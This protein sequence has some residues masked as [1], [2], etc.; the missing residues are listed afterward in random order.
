[1]NRLNIY[2]WFLVVFAT[3]NAASAQF[4]KNS[5]LPFVSDQ[6]D[7]FFSQFGAPVEIILAVSGIVLGF[8]LAFLGALER[9]RPLTAF[10]AGALIGFLLSAILLENIDA[11]IDNEIWVSTFFA[12]GVVFGLICA[13][14]GTFAKV[15][16][17][18]ALGISFT[19]LVLQSGIPISQ[20]VTIGILA[21]SIIIG[22]IISCKV[23]DLVF[24]LLAS[25]LGG[26]FII[27]GVGY[28]TNSEISLNALVADPSVVSACTDSSCLIPLIVGG[29]ATLLSL[30][31]NIRRYCKRKKKQKKSGEQ[32]EA[33]VQEMRTNRANYEKRIE[34]L[35]ASN[36]KVLRELNE[37]AGKREQNLMENMNETLKRTQDQHNQE[38]VRIEKALA[39]QQQEMKRQQAEAQK[40]QE[41]LKK[42]LLQAN[43]S[44]EKEAAL[45]E[46]KQRME[47]E[48]EEKLKAMEIEKM[49]LLRQLQE[50]KSD[51]EIELEREKL[52]QAEREAEIEREQEK[53]REERDKLTEEEDAE[54]RAAI[55]A[56][57]EE[58]QLN[59]LRI[60]QLEEEAKDS[61]K[62]EKK[63]KL[64]VDVNSETMSEEMIE[65]ANEFAQYKDLVSRTRK[66]QKDSLKNV[67]NAIKDVEKLGKQI[68]KEEGK[69][70]K[71][72]PVEVRKKKERALQDMEARMST[73]RALLA[74]Y[75]ENTKA[76]KELIDDMLAQLESYQEEEKRLEAL[77]AEETLVDVEESSEDDAVLAEDLAEGD[78]VPIV[79]LRRRRR[80]HRRPQEQNLGVGDLFQEMYR[81]VQFKRGKPYK[82][83]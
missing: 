12:S 49:E 68:K 45:L 66:L 64:K 6:L 33:L 31:I 69:K 32:S 20:G 47:L 7:E 48:K 23:I 10:I 40:Q 25:F 26:S 42:E 30:L 82:R 5:T 3:I 37:Q 55:L 50:S 76:F 75:E 80:R 46:Q 8:V 63:L 36:E 13:C 4:I 67:R 35:Q 15:L 53:E 71:D 22:V 17:G 9:G 11:E 62:L 60:Q 21:V 41:A 16:L 81:Y 27:L 43:L 39:I 72:D 51:L 28:F 58:A 29:V 70:S 59:K 79:A 73:V 14:I 57:Q 1:M 74:Q 52:A 34:K 61:A 44:Q 65:R 19:G 54:R 24:A 83:Y 38:L 77:E 78:G 2:T 56:L 18:V